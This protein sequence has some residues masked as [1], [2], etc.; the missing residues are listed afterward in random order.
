MTACC[1]ARGAPALPVDRYV[2]VQL[3]DV[4][5][6]INAGNSTRCASVSVDPSG[7]TYDYGTNPV[8]ATKEAIWQQAGIGFVFLPTV[9]R[10]Y[11]G[12]V[13]DLTV[14]GTPTDEAHHL[15]R[16][17][18]HGQNAAS[19]TLKVFFVDSLT[20]TNGTPVYARA[21]EGS[22]GSMGLAWPVGRIRWIRR[23]SRF[24]PSMAR[25]PR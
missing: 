5:N 12:S 7:S 18:G 3:I 13:L 23:A 17:A 9:N 11:N 14:D 6:G 15:F 22:N 24:S 19:P 10:F 2:T 25:M 21:L 8:A 16:D 4:C 1:A 20:A